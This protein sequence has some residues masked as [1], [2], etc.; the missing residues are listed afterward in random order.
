MDFKNFIRKEV[1]SKYYRKRLLKFNALMKIKL[2]I[3]LMH[4]LMHKEVQ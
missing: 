1:I 4:N 2:D 3:R